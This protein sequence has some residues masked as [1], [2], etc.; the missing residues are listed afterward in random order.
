MFGHWANLNSP[1]EEEVAAV[2]MASHSRGRKFDAGGGGGGGRGGGGGGGKG[3]KRRSG[4]ARQGGVT[5]ENAREMYGDNAEDDDE[6]R[7][8]RLLHQAAIYNN[9]E[10]LQVCDW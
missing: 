6:E 2:G 7:P 4:D 9:V 10:L 3:E 8:G 1:H 5:K